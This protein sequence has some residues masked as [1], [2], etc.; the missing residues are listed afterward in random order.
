GGV[1]TDFLVNK[2]YQP[3]RGLYYPRYNVVSTAPFLAFFFGMLVLSMAHYWTEYRNAAPG[4]H[5][6]RIGSLRI[7]FAIGYIGIL[8]FV[9]A[10]GIRIYP[11]GYFPV[12][13]FIVVAVRA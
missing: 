11:F 6:R 10:Y 1:A 2:V 3:L 8:D 4:T 13:D 7:A 12:L 9:A 5:R